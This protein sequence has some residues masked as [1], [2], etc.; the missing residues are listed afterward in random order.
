MIILYRTV[1]KAV[2]GDGRRPRGEIMHPVLFKSPKSR[3]TLDENS[4][5]NI[6]IVCLFYANNY[7]FN[8]LLNNGLHTLILHYRRII[9]TV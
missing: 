7:L 3:G 9:S 8:D 6:Y 1:V 2:G 4:I 5:V